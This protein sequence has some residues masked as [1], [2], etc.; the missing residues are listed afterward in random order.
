MKFV[1]FQ[2]RKKLRKTVRE[3][4]AGKEYT[5]YLPDVVEKLVMALC[6]GRNYKEKLKEVKSYERRAFLKALNNDYLSLKQIRNIANSIE[7]KNVKVQ[8][9]EGKLLQ[10]SNAGHPKKKVIFGFM[11]R[12]ANAERAEQ[13]K[14]LCHMQMLIVLFLEGKHA[15]ERLN[16]ARNKGLWQ[17]NRYQWSENDVF[18][19]LEQDGG[20]RS[21][22]KIENLLQKKFKKDISAV[23]KKRL[24]KQIQ[25]TVREII[26]EHFREAKDELEKI[27]YEGEDKE[28]KDKRAEDIF[29]LGFIERMV[30]K[31]LF[32][33]RL[34]CFKLRL[35]WLYQFVWRD[36]V[37][38]LALKYIDMGK[39]V[40]HFAMPDLSDRKG[41]MR[42]KEAI[43][44]A[45]EITSFDYELIK[46][47][48][49]LERDLSIYI[50]FAVNR[51]GRAVAPESSYEKIDY[52]KD[53]YGKIKEIDYTDLLFVNCGFSIAEK[54]VS[55]SKN[56]FIVYADYQRRLLQYFGGQSRYKDIKEEKNY[57]LI[58]CMRDL[59]SYVRN[60]AFHYTGKINLEEKYE[61]ALLENIYQQEQAQVNRHI[62]EKY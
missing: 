62:R 42:I 43:L 45:N 11:K 1:T 56:K 2:L 21:E 35:S 9:G 24:R 17:K 29:W 13:D 19:F 39:A 25:E 14:M 41:K 53:K 36:W 54:E 6:A 37:S 49:T 60:Y 16:Q 59:L 18:G 22:E 58:C 15:G 27:E 57:E 8:I 12:Y 26:S 55:D 7:K 48:E 52:K 3:Q 51:L 40:Y 30:E 23:E 28:I 50:S 44:P 32:E 10:L 61:N 46:A 4:E 31:A 34:G 38:Y 20:K 33:N 47:D 5:I